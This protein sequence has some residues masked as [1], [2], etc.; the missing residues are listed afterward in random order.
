MSYPF[1]PSFHDAGLRRGPI[2]GFLVHMAEGGGTVGYLSRPNTNGVS[3]H[4]V[5]EYSGQI[6][7]MLVESHMHTSI[8]IRN[9]DGSSAIRQGTGADGFGVANARAVLGDWYDVKSTLGPNHSTIAVEVEGFANALTATQRQNHPRA[10]PLGGPNDAQSTSLVRLVEDVRARNTSIRGNTGHRDHNVKACPGPRIPWAALGGHGLY[11]TTPA[12]APPQEPE[13]SFDRTIYPWPAPREW[14]VRAGTK[15]EGWDP[16]VPGVPVKSMT[17]L[18]DSSAHADAEVWFKWISPSPGAPDGGPFY[19]VTDGFFA[20]LH[21]LADRVE[22]QP[23][24]TP[25]PPT[26]AVLQP[27]LY[28]VK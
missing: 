11:A 19:L 25:T 8:R 26:A 23:A 20:G 10:D 21:I 16:L 14:I 4:Y 2:R 1:V 12:P 3:V 28:E 15:L 6:V 24:P 9:L 22:L 5:I 13:M 27:G 17:F 7:Q 18:T